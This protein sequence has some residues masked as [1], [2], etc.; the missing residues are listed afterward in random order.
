MF[1][2][3]PEG[4]ALHPFKD[5]GKKG[6]RVKT[7]IWWRAYNKVKHEFSENFEKA[8]L[9][10]VRDALAG[11]FLLNVRHT[12]G[13]LRLYDYDL[14]EFSTAFLDRR[15]FL[16]LLNHEERFKVPCFIQTPLFRYD[17]IGEE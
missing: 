4:I 12:P 8:T 16:E 14:V 6:E 10:N 5:Y 3:L 2:C 7:P 15:D 11:A 1:K 9:R 17:Y 13:A